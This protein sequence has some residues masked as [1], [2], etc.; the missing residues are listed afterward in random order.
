MSYTTFSLKQEGAVL[1]VALSN[2]PVNLMNLK[3]TEELFQLSGQLFVDT[4]VKVVILESAD[5]E[6]F[7]AHFDLDDLVKSAADPTKASKYPDINALQALALSWQGLPQVTIAKVQGRCRGAGLEFAMG[8]T[9][10]FASEDSKFC[11]PEASGGFLACGGGTTRIALAA[12]PA[13]ALEFLLSGRDY[14]GL[15]A[16]RYGLVNRALPA[17]ELDQY[18]DDLAA[19]ISQRSFGVIGMHRDVFKEV[20]APMID[21][22][23]AGLAKENDGLRSAM[24]TEE[25]AQGIDGLRSLGQSREYELN[26][27]ET[28]SNLSQANK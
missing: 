28:I 6:F 26:L 5:P 9:M 16:E 24:A 2:P 13:R 25:F 11:A 4:S 18:V 7:I 22:L 17:S 12:G 21:P 27:P 15:E 20:Y 3:M 23:F 14:S 1:R 19:Q 8:L 10:R